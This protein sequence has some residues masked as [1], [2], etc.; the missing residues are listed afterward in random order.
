MAKTRGC[1]VRRRRPC[2]REASRKPP[3]HGAGNPP[4]TTSSP[5]RRD[6]VITNWRDG[7]TAFE[8]RDLEFPATGRRT[9][10]TSSPRYFRGPLGTPQREHSVRQMVDGVAGTITSW[11]APGRLLRHRRRRRGVPGRADL[12]AGQP[13]GRLQLPVWF[14]VGVEPEPQCSA[15]Q[16]Y[17]AGQHP[18]RHGADR[19][20]GRAPGH[21][22]RRLRR[23]RRDR[24]RA[25][26]ANGDKRVFGCCSAMARSSR[27][28]PT[29]WCTPCPSG[30]AWDLVRV[31]QLRPGMR[32]HL[33]PHRESADDLVGL[34]RRPAGRGRWRT[35]TLVRRAGHRGVRGGPRRLAAGRRLRRPVRDRDQ[36][37]AH[38]RV[39]DRDRGGRQV[40][41]HLQVVFPDVHQH[42]RTFRD[43]RHH[44]HR[45]AAPALRRSPTAVR[46]WGLLGR[47]HDLRCRPGS[48][49]RP[50]GGRR[51]PSQSPDRRYVT[52]QRGSG[53]VAFAVIGER[54]TEDIQV[55]FLRLGIYSRR[56][57]KA[58][59][60][61]TA[62]TCSRCRSACAPAVDVPSKVRSCRPGSGDAG[63]L[64]GAGRRDVPVAPR[65]EIVAI[66]DR[67]VQPVFDIQTSGE[68]LSNN[69]R[70][71]N[72]F[73]LSV[74]DT[75]P[76]D[77]Q[78]VCRGGHDLQG[79]GRASTCRPSARP[80]SSSA[81]AAG[82]RG[83]CRSCAGADAS[84]GPS[85]RAARPG[86]RQD[87]RAQRRPP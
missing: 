61:P 24:V 21:R 2:R 50:R 72:C 64:P 23:P 26:K 65:R 43:R 85:S 12:P 58:E 33:Y 44:P 68:Y 19:R 10:P 81:T 62:P 22:D 38:D 46:V 77:P 42:V 18:E 49:T 66:E 39:R 20:A 45:G 69:I 84:A 52:V 35:A 59:P 73:I 3:V 74:S 67:G 1:P 56:L 41:R 25:V 54:W 47:R 6:A 60:G 8:Q 48:G 17:D 15:C 86:G 37:L 76:V 31:D 57:R 11:G 78:L 7:T 14:N 5:G 63:R 70:V 13:E 27:R 53:R 29:T 30:G 28:P 32:L 36:H 79:R 16:P 83:R 75:M 40:Q 9:P 4:P 55:L 80:G 82:A 51:L 34:R 71:H 87:G